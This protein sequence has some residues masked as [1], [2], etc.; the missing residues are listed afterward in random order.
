M[1]FPFQHFMGDLSNYKE[2]DL[3][4]FWLDAI[5]SD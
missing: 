4:D 1:N 3:F 5:S 2:I